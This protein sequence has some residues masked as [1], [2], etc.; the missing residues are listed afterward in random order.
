[1]AEDDLVLAERHREIGQRRFAY[2][3][4]VDRHLR[5]GLRIDADAAVR[6]PAR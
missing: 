2:I 1:V 6:R 4:A 3:P 5:P